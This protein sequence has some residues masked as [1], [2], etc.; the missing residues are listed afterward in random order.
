MKRMKT[1]SIIL[2]FG[3]SLIILGL[4]L[5]Y[6]SYDE[7]VYS[8]EIKPISQERDCAI[9]A[10]YYEARNT[11][12]KEK[13]AVLEI[14]LNRTKHKSYPS[15]IC[16]VI[17]QP[18][19]MSYRNNFSYNAKL[20]PKFETLNA[21]D[22]QSYLEI[23]QIVDSKLTPSRIKL[24]NILP[25]NTIYYHTKNIDKIPKWTK[26]KRLKKIL[27]DNQFKHVYYASAN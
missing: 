19:Q 3:F 1:T 4:S 20:I 27:I 2:A 13:S 5:G 8:T 18:K 21:I 7:E 25:N 15:T 11:I 14:V 26:D 17:K 10:L 24:N 9:E 16:E 23:E 6:F 22:K 12:H